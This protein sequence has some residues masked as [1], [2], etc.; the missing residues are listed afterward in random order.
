MP[1]IKKCNMLHTNEGYTIVLARVYWV[2]CG[3]EKAFMD[4]FSGQKMVYSNSKFVCSILRMCC[5]KY[6]LIFNRKKP[7]GILGIPDNHS[8]NVYCV[9]CTVHTGTL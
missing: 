1:C 8:K 9:V 5:T 4:I 2:P 3:K 6:Q 7:V